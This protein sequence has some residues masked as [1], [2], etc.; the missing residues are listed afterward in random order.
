MGP[1]FINPQPITKKEIQ[2]HNPQIHCMYTGQKRTNPKKLHTYA[3]LKITKS[4]SSQLL[5]SRCNS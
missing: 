2:G 3:S 5:L 4:F 1:I